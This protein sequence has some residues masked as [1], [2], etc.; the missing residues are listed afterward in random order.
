[1]EVKTMNKPDRSDFGNMSEFYTAMR[2]YE[3]FIDNEKR[4]KAMSKVVTG[5][6]VTMVAVVGLTVL[7]GSWYTV[8]QGERGVILRNGAITGMAEPGLGFKMP[9]VDSV[10]DIDV[11][12]QVVVYDNILA[13]SRDQQTANLTVSVNYRVP[14]DAVKTV[15]EDYGSVASL[16]NRLLDRQV[17]DKSKSVFG[18]FNA[19][20]AIQ[21][22]ARLV[23]EVQ[24]AI[25]EAVVGPI[26]IES[27]QIENIDFSDTYEQS[28]E[29]RMLAEVEVQKVEQNK[30]REVVQ[31]EIKVIQAKATA[32]ARV[33]SATAEAEAIRLRGNAEA[34]A[35]TARGEALNENP[36]LVALVQ[37]ERWNGVLPTTMLPNSTVPFMNMN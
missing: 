22:R 15:Y 8:D 28:I 27:V 20:E 16:A 14:A 23:T 31:A 5:A 29:Q 18:Q 30:N 24:M 2:N 11:R 35:I 25:Q 12:S 4:K 13:Y 34:E 32:E 36:S 3:E 17:M 21:E 1:M 26:T 19:V 6:V 33:A 10:V 9:I 37:A 7:G